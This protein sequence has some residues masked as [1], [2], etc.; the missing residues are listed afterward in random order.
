MDTVL[1]LDGTYGPITSDTLQYGNLITDTVNGFKAARL[2]NFNIAMQTTMFGRIDFKNGRWLKGIRHVFKPSISF[3]YTPDYTSE[4]LGYFRTVDD[5]LRPLYN[6]PELYNIFANSLYNRPDASGLKAGIGIGITNIF[7]AKYFSK[8]DSADKIFKLFDNVSMRSFYNF[9][10]DSMKWQPLSMSGTMRLFNSITT[11]TT[12]ARFSPYVKENGRITSAYLWDRKK[13]IARLDDFTLGISSSFRLSKLQEI[14]AKK[15]KKKVDEEEEEEDDF[16]DDENTVIPDDPF[17]PDQDP[18]RRISERNKERNLKPVESESLFDAFKDFRVYHNFAFSLQADSS[19]NVQPK[20]S[21]NSI[22]VQGN[23]QLTDNWSIRVGN[24]GYDFISKSLSY[25][26]IGIL[27]DLHCW[28]MSFNWQPVRG[29]Y[30]FMIR[31]KGN[32]LNFIKIP[33]NKNN[34]DTF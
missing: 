6:N 8:K 17:N 29:T 11:V 9:A 24:I 22:N 2:Y 13:Q 23:L 33:Y 31:V 34:Q 3:N 4:K 26:D 32:S 7:E 12:R 16:F 5:D 19:G 1:N 30:S 20:I 14:F 25:P 15:R 27:R 21:A 18:N 28:E 10:A